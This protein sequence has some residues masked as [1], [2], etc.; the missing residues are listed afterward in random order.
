MGAKV[1]PAA[2]GPYLCRVLSRY[3]VVAASL[4]FENIAGQVLA[5]PAGYLRLVWSGQPRQLADTQQLLQAVAAQLAQRRWGR[6]LADQTHMRPFT[7][8][9]Q[10]W[11]SQQWLPHEARASGYRAG[12]ILVASSVLSRLATAYITSSSPENAFLRYRSFDDEQTA[13][14]WLLR[15]P[16]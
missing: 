9:E 13:T 6:V 3:L 2:G 10:R 15:Q 14:E 12:A 4:L 8:D 11:V 7:P 16:A 5:D 1:Q